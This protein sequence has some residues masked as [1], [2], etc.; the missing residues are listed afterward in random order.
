MQFLVRFQISP[1]CFTASCAILWINWTNLV[2]SKTGEGENDKEGR[3]AGDGEEPRKLT[4]LLVRNL[5]FRLSPLPLRIR[6]APLCKP[7][8]L[9]LS[10]LSFTNLHSEFELCMLFFLFRWNLLMTQGQFLRRWL[11]LSLTSSFL[12]DI[13]TGDSV[14]SKRKIKAFVLC[15]FY[16]TLKSFS[17]SFVVHSVNEGYLRYTQF[18]ALQHFSSAALSVLS[19]QVFFLLHSCFL[20][21]SSTS[22]LLLHRPCW[23]SWGLKQLQTEE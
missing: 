6:W 9:S 10:P 1:F 4:T 2:K 13:L 3:A 20:V 19:T 5:R 23:D 12:L 8:S 21:L 17:F 18:R 15:S 16:N 11:S 14:L 7:L 22:F